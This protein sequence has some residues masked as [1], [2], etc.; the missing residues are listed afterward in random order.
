MFKSQRIG[1]LLFAMSEAAPMK[2]HQYYCPIVRQTKTTPVGTESRME[3]SEHFGENA[4]K[5]RQE[6]VTS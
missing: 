4:K 1:N 3:D 2:S 5:T 6:P